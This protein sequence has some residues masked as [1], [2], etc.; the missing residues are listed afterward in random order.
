MVLPPR[1]QEALGC[2]P[3]AKTEHHGKVKKKLFR[4]SKMLP[5]Q[6][7]SINTFAKRHLKEATPVLWYPCLSSLNSTGK[8]LERRASQKNGVLQCF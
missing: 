7:I 2:L 4:L 5:G 8:S 1:H 6:C 3:R